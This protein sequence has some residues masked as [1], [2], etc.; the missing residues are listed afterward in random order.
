LLSKTVMQNPTILEARFWLAE[1]LIDAG[2]LEEAENQLESLLLLVKNPGQLFD[3]QENLGIIHAK[4]GKLA[5][6]LANFNAASRIDP[7]DPGLHT[8]IAGVLEQSGLVADA[9]A[10]YRR[11]LALDPNSAEALNKLA[12]IF[13]T[14]PDGNFRNGGEAI[15]LAEKAC[16]QTDYKKLDFVGTLGAA[17][18]EAGRFEDAVA[19]AKQA[20]TI[21]LTTGE[22]NLA[23]I[24]RDLSKL[25]ASRMAFHGSFP[26][27]SSISSE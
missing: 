7:D 8:H 4:Q 13:A 2:N 24:N 19:T 10:H 25:F 21:A 5:D 17:Y 1:A 3:I 14:N 18:A 27:N 12:W 6:A 9:I 11:A 23:S 20:Q 15:L 16:K 26:T 22:T